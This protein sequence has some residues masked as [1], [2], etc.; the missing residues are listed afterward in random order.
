MDFYQFVNEDPS[1]RKIFH[2]FL[3]TLS[4]MLLEL[5]YGHLSGSLGLVS[6]G[7]HM[8]CDSMALIIG[9]VVSYISKSKSQSCKYPFGLVKIEPLFGLINGLFLIFVSLSLFGKSI[10]KMRSPGGI[11]L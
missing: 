9:L 3:L 1:S 5:V 2:F 10:D 7:V 4:F 11:S 8:L 6:D